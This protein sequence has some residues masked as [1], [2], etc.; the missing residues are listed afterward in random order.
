MKRIA[1]DLVKLYI[2]EKIRLDVQQLKV[3]SLANKIRKYEK[4]GLVHPMLRFE[5]NVSFRPN[6]KKLV[7]ELVKKFMKDGQR[8]IFMK[9]LKKRF[10]PKKG[11]VKIHIETPKYDDHRDRIL[12]LREKYGLKKETPE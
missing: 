6:W 10:K 11:L 4:R 7:L 8:V 9:S 3:I 1:D 5:D 2:A 12:R